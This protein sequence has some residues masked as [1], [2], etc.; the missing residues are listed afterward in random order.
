MKYRFRRNLERHSREILSATSWSSRPAIPTMAML[1]SF[2]TSE[3]WPSTMK[4]KQS[5]VKLIEIWRALMTFH[6]LFVVLGTLTAT[7]PTKP[8]NF[9]QRL[10]SLPNPADY[11]VILLDDDTAIEYDC[12]TNLF[13]EEYCVH[14]M[15]RTPTI[16]P[17]KLETMIKYASKFYHLFFLL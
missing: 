8:G 14:F 11:N 4:C 2:T 6:L 15:S 9:E 12:F 10:T 17:D 5:Q 7:S 3:I 1:R 13:V 16:Q